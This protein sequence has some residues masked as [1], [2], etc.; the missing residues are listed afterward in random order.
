MNMLGIV[1]GE[2]LN[3]LFLTCAAMSKRGRSKRIHLPSIVTPE[4]Y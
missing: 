3:S 1:F 2:H 4:H